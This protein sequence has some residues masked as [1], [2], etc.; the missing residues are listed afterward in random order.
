[1]EDRFNGCMA[2]RAFNLRIAS[3][4]GIDILENALLAEGM[5]AFR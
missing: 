5:P 2:L 3:L 1:M 4:E